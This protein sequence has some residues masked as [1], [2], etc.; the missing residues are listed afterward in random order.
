MSDDTPAP[1]PDPEAMT[2]EQVSAL[3]D[4]CDLTM[5]RRSQLKNLPLQAVSCASQYRSYGGNPADIITAVQA[6]IDTQEAAQ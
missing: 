4:A 3:R 6:W 1:V 5:A 2:N